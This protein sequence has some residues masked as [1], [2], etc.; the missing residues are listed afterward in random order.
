[1]LSP[2]R[3]AILSI[4]PEYGFA[5]P[6]MVALLR[7]WNLYNKTTLKEDYDDYKLLKDVLYRPRRKDVGKALKL[8]H[9]PFLE[10]ALGRI[11]HLRLTKKTPGAFRPDGTT[12][13]LSP[14]MPPLT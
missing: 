7:Q 8:C 5:L 12:R 6:G 10:I 2:F 4:P 14:S 9:G 11:I 13:R 3:C 1:M